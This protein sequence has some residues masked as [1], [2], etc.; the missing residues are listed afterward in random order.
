M[1]IDEYVCTH[2]VVGAERHF[3]SMTVITSREL[4]RKDRLWCVFVSVDR[5]CVWCVVVCCVVV[6][7]Q[8]PGRAGLDGPE[9]FA[10]GEELSQTAQRRARYDG[11]DE[12]DRVVRTRLGPVSQSVV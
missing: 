12:R 6:Y 4:T 11:A 2:T 9:P 8:W 7:L 10:E 5:G 1:T 3:R